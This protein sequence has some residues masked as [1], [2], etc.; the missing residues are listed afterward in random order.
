MEL[1]ACG[2]GKPLGFTEK[3]VMGPLFTHKTIPNHEYKSFK[4]PLQHVHLRTAIEHQTS[5]RP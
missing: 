3:Q 2:F 5:D 1:L 4:H